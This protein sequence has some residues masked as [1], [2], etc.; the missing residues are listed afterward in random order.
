MNAGARGAPRQGAAPAAAMLRP[1]RA[2]ALRSWLGVLV[3]TAGCDDGA[4]PPGGTGGGGGGGGATAL[5]IRDGCNPIAA[6]A[7]CLVPYPSDVFLVADPGTVTDRR[8][9]VPEPARILYDEGPIDLGRLHPAD[10]FSWQGPILALFPGGVDASALPSLHD[11]PSVSTA[12]SSPTVLVDAETGEQ[13]P[14]F[15]ELDPRAEDDTRRALVIRP[16]VRLAPSRRYVVGIHGLPGKDGALAP[17]PAGF[18]DLRDRGGTGHP[19]LAAL[20][21]RYDAGVFRVL[22]AIAP[23]GEW[24]LAWDFTTASR[25]HAQAD[26]LRVRELTLAALDDAGGAPSFTVDEM[27]PGDGALGV[28]VNGTMTVPLFLDDAGPG[29]RLHRGDDG[30][31]AAN[32]TTEVPWSAWIPRSVL[33]RTPGS[34]PARLLQYGHGFFGDRNEVNGYPVDLADEHG[35]VVVAVDWWGMS[36][37]DRG[38][39]VVAINGDPEN[40]FR[41]TDRVHQAM[42]NQIALAA[43]ASGPLA[44]DEALQVGG[45]PAYDPGAVYFHGNSMGHILGGTYVAL[46]PHVERAALGVGGANFSMML[47]RAR[48]FAI[49]LQLLASHTPDALDQQKFGVFAQSSFDRIDPGSFA[50]Y[51][52]DEALP[53][54][55]ATRHVLMHAGID[56]ASVTLLAAAYH[57]RALGLP[58]LE[59]SPAPVPALETASYPA[60]DGFVL[61]DFGLDL[62]LIETASLPEGENLVHDAVRNSPAAKEQVSGFLREGGVIE[63]TCDG[64]CDP[65]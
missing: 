50:E 61:F 64:A 44:D 33:E 9:E 65:D 52:R 54:A 22:E 4:M 46:A 17:S 26:L 5:V 28:R 45:A 40:T 34:A 36:S 57:A 56:D 16:L 37:D 58:L 20:A 19:A 35:F 12:P 27:V 29:A 55:P 1:M 13:V 21:P 59:P 31:V 49:F 10:G 48:P 62:G 3:L 39:V 14:H 63:Q 23:R 24:Q 15:A 51:V 11:D 38:E 2:L 41:F 30:A 6:D 47:F 25:E 7:D 43:L 32:G 53:G 18:A 8:V 42:A 60:D